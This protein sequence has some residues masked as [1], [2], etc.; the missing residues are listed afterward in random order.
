MAFHLVPYVAVGPLRFG[1]ERAEI[2]TLLGPSEVSVKPFGT[3]ECDD[4][5]SLGIFVEYDANSQ[6]AYVA[7]AAPT[8]VLYKGKDLLR[9]TVKQL[10]KLLADDAHL[11]TGGDTLTSRLH[12]T[13]AVFEYKTKPVARITAFKKGYYDQSDE[14]IRK[15]ETLNLHEMSDE[16]IWHFIENG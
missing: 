14:K 6:C 3:V 2:H 7:L 4:Y 15:V 8:A 9:L 16:E 11:E 13:G 5:P 10:S 1:M 12:G